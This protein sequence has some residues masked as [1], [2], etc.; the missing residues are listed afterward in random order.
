MP[1]VV[2]MGY[3]P[4]QLQFFFR[5]CN[6]TSKHYPPPTSKT[7][8]YA[9]F[10]CWWLF[11]STSTHHQPRKQVHML[12]FEVGGCSASPPPTTNLKN[13]HPC[14][15]LRVRHTFSRYPHI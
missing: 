6:W 8:V 5:F 13:E 10:R 14:L 12:V 15:F 11:S 9:R 2:L 7:S 1:F 4:V 3:G